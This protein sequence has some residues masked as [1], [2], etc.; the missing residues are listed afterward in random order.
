MRCECHR[1]PRARS[2]ARIDRAHPRFDPGAP[3]SARRATRRTAALPH[4]RTPP[5]A[6][7][8][9][10]RGGRPAPSSLRATRGHL[11]TRVHRP[12]RGRPRAFRASRW[13][14]S[15]WPCTVELTR[16]DELVRED[17]TSPRRSAAPA[18]AT[19]QA[20]VPPP[21]ARA[22]CLAP[23][24]SA[25]TRSVREPCTR[26]ATSPARDAAS[27]ASSACSRPPFRVLS[28]V[29]EVEV[30]LGLEGRVALSLGERLATELNRLDVGRRDPPPRRPGAPRT[31]ARARPGGAASRACS[32]IEI[33]RPTV[34]RL[35]Q[36]V[37]TD[38]DAPTRVFEIVGRREPDRQLGQLGG[39][40]GRSP[41]VR[42]L[43]RL[44]DCGGD[45]TARAG[46]QRERDAA[47]VP[48]C[49]ERPRRAACGATAGSPVWRATRPPTGAGGA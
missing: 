32:S 38:E 44:L 24:G 20:V 17:R 2:H 1:P 37:G 40:S 31:A 4:G 14:S 30:D 28:E 23:R 18:A 45:L 11:A 49:S 13:S 7:A 41:R 36:P 12:P 16:P 10:P 6:R 8:N 39:G 29:G 27:T 26:S 47:L 46:P 22:E 5:G 3:R 15:E 21:S 43:C 35:P 34:A 33:A 42:A 19:A 25:R 48:P 9:R